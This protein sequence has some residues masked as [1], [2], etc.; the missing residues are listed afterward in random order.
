MHLLDSLRGPEKDLL[1]TSEA[2]ISS[3]LRSSLDIL[4]KFHRQLDRYQVD[5]TQAGIA[6]HKRGQSQNGD[7]NLHFLCLEIQSIDGFQGNLV[8]LENQRKK[9]RLIRSLEKLDAL[10]SDESRGFSNSALAVIS[11]PQTLFL[12][13]NDEDFKRCAVKKIPSGRQKRYIDIIDRVIYITKENDFA[14]RSIFQAKVLAYEKEI[15]Q[16]IQDCLE[17][18]QLQAYARTVEKQILKEAQCEGHL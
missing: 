3:H 12:K 18:K 11:D 4:R 5:T 1:N 15:D 17:Q 7:Q 8:S 10:R 6:I 2:N 9:G 16:I 13:V 14:D